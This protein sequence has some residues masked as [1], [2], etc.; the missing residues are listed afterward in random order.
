MDRDAAG[1]RPD[2]IYRL[3]DGNAAIFVSAAVQGGN[4][5]A[6]RDPEA[7]DILRDLGWS[8]IIIGAEAGWP[9]VVARYPSVFGTQ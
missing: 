6:G 7:H 5:E 1:T 3:P 2:L 8:V 4:E 9:A